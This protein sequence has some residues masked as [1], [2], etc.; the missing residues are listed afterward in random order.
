MPKNTH[1]VGDRTEAVLL[2]RLLEVYETVLLPFGNGQRYDMVAVD[3]DGRFLRIQCKTGHLESGC[4]VFRSASVDSRTK[5]DRSYTGEID[6]FGV[7][8]SQIRKAYLVP[9]ED[10]GKSRTYLHI[11][12]TKNGQKYKTRLAESYELRLSVPS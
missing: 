4:V 10:A 2:A 11:E 9:I 7:Y 6:Y 1:A 5:K 3:K 12:P 8:C